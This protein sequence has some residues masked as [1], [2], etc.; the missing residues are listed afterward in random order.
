MSQVTGNTA[1]V[2]LSSISG[3][4]VVRGEKRPEHL[5]NTSIH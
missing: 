3:I 1:S 2:I 4:F 5:C